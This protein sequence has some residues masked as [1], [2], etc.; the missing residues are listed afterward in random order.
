MSHL[1]LD[2]VTQKGTISSMDRKHL[3]RADLEAYRAGWQ[4]AKEIERAEA[5]GMT[6]EERWREF[7]AI[8]SFAYE[9]GWI[10][11]ANDQELAP[12]RARWARL[13]ARFP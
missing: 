13:K 4:A 6:I 2:A 12:M 8:I 7:N 11:P 3:T 1:A 5:R 10:Q 9:L